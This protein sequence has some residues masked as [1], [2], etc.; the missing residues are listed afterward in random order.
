LAAGGHRLVVLG[1]TGASLGVG[2]CQELVEQLHQPVDDA[3]QALGPKGQQGRVAALGA[4]LGQGLVRR[5]LGQ[6][7]R[8]ASAKGC[9]RHMTRRLAAHLG[10]DSVSPAGIR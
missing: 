7:A 1:E 4:R 8:M 10:I 3:D 5:R 2:V 6:R 9:G